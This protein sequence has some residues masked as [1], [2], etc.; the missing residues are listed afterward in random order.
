VKS[1]KATLLLSVIAVV[2]IGAP[3]ASA[4]WDIPSPVPPG[5][6]VGDIPSPVPPGAALGDIPSP[7]PPGLA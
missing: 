2:L 1:A 6:S 3:A 4:G 7:V 5:V